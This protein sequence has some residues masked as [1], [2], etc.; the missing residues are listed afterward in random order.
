M[1]S[2][3]EDAAQSPAD[4]VSLPSPP[5]NPSSE[6]ST[7]T[8][9]SPSSVS[10]STSTGDIEDRLRTDSIRSP[11]RSPSPSR[12]GALSRFVSADSLRRG[13]SP[14]RWSGS[15]THGREFPA[16]PWVEAPKGKENIPSAQSE[17]WVVTRQVRDPRLRRRSNIDSFVLAGCI[18]CGFSPR[19]KG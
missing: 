15:H 19:Y 6:S 18:C 7:T 12:T 10:S 2:P 1:S 14:S 3:Y 4:H 13:Q 16:R 5:H 9:I 8:K 11:T 17:R